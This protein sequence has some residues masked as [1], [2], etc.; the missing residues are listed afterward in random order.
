MAKE[1]RAAAGSEAVRDQ[2]R[3]LAVGGK[4]EKDDVAIYEVSGSED[5]DLDLD[6]RAFGEGGWSK[7]QEITDAVCEALKR[8]FVFKGISDSLLLDV[9]ER[10][11]GVCFKAGSVVLQQGALPKPDDCMYYLQLGE[12]EVV[13][14]GAVD[15][16]AKNHGEDRKVEGHTVRILQ[17]P[18]WVFGDVALLF[19]SSRTASVIAKTNITVWAGPQNV[20]QV[21]DEARAGSACAALPAQAAAAQGSVGQRSHP[22]R[23][24]HAAARV[25]GWAGA[26]QVRRAW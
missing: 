9:V 2:I 13:I 25:P 12:A 11:Y 24:P 14:S 3:K 4:P 15:S 20:P 18:G 5:E 6:G 8:N 10:M 23:Q 26:Y 19:H 16:G 17:K 1:R 7:P 21:C 22:C